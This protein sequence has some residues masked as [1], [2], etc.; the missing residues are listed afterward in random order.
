MAETPTMVAPSV[1]TFDDE[2]IEAHVFDTP[3][4]YCRVE[5]TPADPH[6][7]LNI[8]TPSA[9]TS[10]SQQ[11][12]NA[13]AV[14]AAARDLLIVNRPTR[15]T[16]A[17]QAVSQE[18]RALIADRG[19]TQQE[20]AYEFGLSQSTLSAL[21]NGHSRWTLEAACAIAS[22]V[23]GAFQRLMKIYEEVSR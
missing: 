12:E 3:T 8:D 4:M 1:E 5:R 11:M 20:A 22:S 6:W 2:A 13:R 14:A 19:W 10:R 17:D 16:A 9:A 21:L 18:V 15:G 23:D 7:S